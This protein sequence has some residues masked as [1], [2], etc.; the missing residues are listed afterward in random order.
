MIKKTLKRLKAAI[1]YIIPRFYFL[2]N[3]TLIMWIGR[4][5]YF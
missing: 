1:R 4:E 2:E 5:F 3:G